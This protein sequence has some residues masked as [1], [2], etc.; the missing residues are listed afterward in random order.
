[1]DDENNIINCNL[2][3][4]TDMQI[5]ANVFLAEQKYNKVI[6]TDKNGNQIQ[7][8]NPKSMY[9]FLEDNPENIDFFSP[10]TIINIGGAAVTLSYLARL[11]ESGETAASGLGKVATG[12]NALAVLIDGAQFLQDPNLD[13]GSDMIFTAIGFAGAPGAAISLGLTYTKKGIVEGSRALTNF[14]MGYEKFYIN[15]WS[16][17]LFRVNIK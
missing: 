1:V 17:S 5:A 10:E 13:T 7:F 4:R 16:Q 2:D 11:A 12:L 15:R 14:S 3:D 9:A 8:N 6:A